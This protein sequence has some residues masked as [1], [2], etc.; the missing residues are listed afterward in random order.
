MTGMCSLMDIRQKWSDDCVEP[1]LPIFCN[2]EMVRFRCC[3]SK[4]DKM[5]NAQTLVMGG[6]GAMVKLLY[7][8]TRAFRV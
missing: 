2:A 6:S 4:R 5:S 1:T 8:V 3:A 7:P